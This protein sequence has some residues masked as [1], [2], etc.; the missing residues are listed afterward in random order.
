MEVRARKE[1]K[2]QRL[3]REK[4]EAIRAKQRLWEQEKQ[5]QEQSLVNLNI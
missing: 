4:E 1:R 2:E 3:K 5:R